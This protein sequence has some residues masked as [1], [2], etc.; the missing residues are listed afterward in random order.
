VNLSDL[1]LLDSSQIKDLR[2]AKVT[3]AKLVA[4]HLVMAG[5]IP[6]IPIIGYRAIL[7]EIAGPD[8]DRRDKPRTSPAMTPQVLLLLPAKCQRSNIPYPGP[9]GPAPSREPPAPGQRH[10]REDM[11]AFR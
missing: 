8:R 3:A 2:P 5:L 4:P 11:T 9:K 7:I 10:I 1:I 6:A